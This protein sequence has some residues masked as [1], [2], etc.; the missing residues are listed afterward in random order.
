MKKK[1]L[2]VLSGMALLFIVIVAVYFSAFIQPKIVFTVEI[3][4]VSNEDYKR[5]LNNAQVMYPNKDIEK[6]K[7][8]NIEIKVTEP[9]GVNNNIKIE[10]DILQQYLKDNKK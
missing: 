8:I 3:G 7:H 5:I 2:Y 4:T 1:V 6:F 10:R 9:V